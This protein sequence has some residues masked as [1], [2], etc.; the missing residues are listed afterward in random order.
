MSI[1]IPM[2]HTVMRSS[3]PFVNYGPVAASV[4]VGSAFQAYRGGIF[5]TTQNGQVNHG[6]VL[7]GWDDAQGTNGVWIL[8]NSWGVG[9]SE[10]GYMRIDYGTSQVGYAATYIV[11]T[12]ITADFRAEPSYGENPCTVLFSDQSTGNITSRS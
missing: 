2:F 7:V 1:P 6:V 3:K 9:C 11:Y 4:Y 12:P 5:N 8:R 10:R